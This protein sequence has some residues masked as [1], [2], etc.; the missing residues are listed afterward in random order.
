MAMA[1][2][3]GVS[4]SV[5][6]CVAVLAGVAR[7]VDLRRLRRDAAEG[8]ERLAHACPGVWV[9]VDEN[10]GATL[11]GGDEHGRWA[12]AVLP[13]GLFAPPRLR[14]R[15]RGL[16]WT[17]GEMH[18]Q[19]R[20]QRWSAIAPPLPMALGDPD[21]QGR[22]EH[23]SLRDA[24]L[25]PGLLDALRALDVTALVVT[26]GALEATL[27]REPSDLDA[28]SLGALGALVRALGGT[29]FNARRPEPAAVDAR[30]RHRPS[31]EARD[32]AGERPGSPSAP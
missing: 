7:R 22:C 28:A 18:L 23:A 14:L 12:L 11:H 26:R 20:D 16:G 30:A 10:A 2:L 27:R 9:A 15:G 6:V 25:P 5:P 13:T 21:Y 17:G 3:G 8:W 19:R 4:L 32:D 24:A 1:A 29:P 31:P